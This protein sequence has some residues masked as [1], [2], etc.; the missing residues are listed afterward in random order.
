MAK[1]WSR[2]KF[3][4]AQFDRPL[5]AYTLGLDPKSLHRH[6]PAACCSGCSF[7]QWV[8]Y[9][10]PRFH[11]TIKIEVMEDVRKGA[12]IIYSWMEKSTQEGMKVV[13]V[14]DDAALIWL[15]SL[16]DI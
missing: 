9:S 10:V 4:S 14:L 8:V 6:S 15:L 11:A 5:A 2:H 16:N 3:A 12:N 1:Y 7:L 13:S